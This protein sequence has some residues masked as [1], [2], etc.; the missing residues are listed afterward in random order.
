M[1]QEQ[2]LTMNGG[3]HPDEGLTELCHAYL[4]CHGILHARS[5]HWRTP[6]YSKSP[7][8]R[9]K[10]DTL[11]NCSKRPR[12]LLVMLQWLAAAFPSMATEFKVFREAMQTLEPEPK[13]V[14]VYNLCKLS[15]YLCWIMNVDGGLLYCIVCVC[16]VFV[17]NETRQPLYIC[18]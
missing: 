1:L 13:Y 14:P 17:A 3:K 9:K 8:E 18:I 5:A 12:V 15:T 4:T 16:N 7:E 2:F 11:E 10:L 6:L